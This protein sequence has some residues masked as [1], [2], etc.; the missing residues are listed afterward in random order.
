MCCLGICYL[1]PNEWP[2]VNTINENCH[3]AA[4]SQLSIQITGGL[5]DGTE[6][7]K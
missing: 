1:S 3:T 5:L 2:T 6:I 4:Q 7:A